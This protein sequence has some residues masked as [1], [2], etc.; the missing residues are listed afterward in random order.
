MEEI[1]QLIICVCVCVCFYFGSTTNPFS[2]LVDWYLIEC[3]KLRNHS[4][5]FCCSLLEFKNNNH[6]SARLPDQLIISRPS[7]NLPQIRVIVITDHAFL[8]SYVP[9]SKSFLFSL[10]QFHSIMFEFLFLFG[11]GRFFTSA[12]MYLLSS[13]HPI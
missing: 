1:N 13:F 12:H 7:V 2:Y 5:F 10:F 9:F 8:R 6:I 11:G 3:F 4:A